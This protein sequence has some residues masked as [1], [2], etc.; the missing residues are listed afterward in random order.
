MTARSTTIIPVDGDD[1]FVSRLINR[2]S[3]ALH[4]ILLSGPTAS[5]KTRKIK[6]MLDSP[7]L[8][9]GFQRVIMLV[10]SHRT[11]N[12]YR[13]VLRALPPEIRR[14]AIELK[15]RP[16]RQC[17]SLNREW[18]RLEKAGCS[19][20]ARRKLC[21]T[22]SRRTRCKWLE[23]A[24]PDNLHDARFIMGV[25]D[26]IWIYRHLISSTDPAT[27]F[28]FDEARLIS[29]AARKR[30]RRADI[31]ALKDVCRHLLPDGGL[32]D[33]QKKTVMHLWRVVNHLLKRRPIESMPQLPTIDH[34]LA[35]MI[36]EAGWELFPDE[37]RYIVP[38]LS[39]LDVAEAAWYTKSGDVGY[40]KDLDLSGHTYLLVSATLPLLLARRKLRDPDIELV[41]D[42]IDIHPGTRLFN[43]ANRM[44]A[45]RNFPGNMKRILDFF[46]SLAARDL[47]EGRRV[48]FITKKDFVR[49][50][51]T[52]VQERL[53]RALGHRVRVFT[54]TPKSR[55]LPPDT[56]VAMITYGFTGTNLYEDFDCCYCLC[57]F[58]ISDVVLNRFLADWLP[59]ERLPHFTIQYDP[60]SGMRHVVG[61]DSRD[62]D[63]C[64]LATA[65]LEY[66][67]VGVV[68]QAIGRCRYM[69][70][71]RIVITMQMT[72]LH[73]ESNMTFHTLDQVRR[74]FMVPSG[75]AT[76]PGRAH[77]ARALH[78]TGN[79]VESIA[80]IMGVKTTTI[81]R[82]LRHSRADAKYI[83]NNHTCRPPITLRKGGTN[84][85]AA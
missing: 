7:D 33:T 46:C 1:R 48:L 9:C 2:L 82:Y 67:E 30:L 41:E 18:C 73:L 76:P 17:G 75:R 63:L 83:N 20:L 28:V 40:I 44:G 23:Q 56:Q 53:S 50:S 19:T 10:D 34:R 59:G 84:G 5:G 8:W 6:L 65:A 12:E 24:D 16:H 25:V 64:A 62:A 72:D 52:G 79:D 78:A 27:L 22:C 71:P 4:G 31:S 47:Q 66:L 3:K 42:S 51:C 45:K 49:D 26:Y 21:S 60:A 39:D 80:Q 70:K 69:T 15:P 14:A 85:G 37:F 13:E 11:L 38:A 61:G 29:Q 32:S 57:S 81:S 43:I 36:Q 68:L 35:A 55:R 77:Q 54:P 74:H 58:N